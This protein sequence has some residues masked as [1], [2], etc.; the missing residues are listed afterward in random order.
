ME[1]FLLLLLGFILGFL[2]IFLIRLG[3]GRMAHCTSCGQ[4]HWVGPGKVDPICKKC[5]APLRIS[6][7]EPRRAAGAGNKKK[8]K[9]RQF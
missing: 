3:Q 8:K 9:Q 7:K 2:L 5:G 6:R 4:Q 1:T